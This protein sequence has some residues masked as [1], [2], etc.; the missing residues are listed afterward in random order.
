MKSLLIL[1]ALAALSGC[2]STA[3]R[4][5]ATAVQK[6]STAEAEC[7]RFGYTPGTQPFQECTNDMR[8]QARTLATAQP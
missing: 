2:T 8:Q 5:D 4:T 3:A 1:S 7:A 6:P